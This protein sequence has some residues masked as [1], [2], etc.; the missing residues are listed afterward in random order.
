MTTAREIAYELLA[1][2]DEEDAYANLVMP[3]LLSAARNS[4]AHFSSRDAGFATELGYGTL[5]MR[6]WLNA[7]IDQVSSRPVD[8]LDASV[9]RVIQL[10]AYQLL[11]M[12]VSTHAAVSETV[13]LCRTVG[14]KSAAGFVNATLR[15]ISE[16][17]PEQWQDDIA[18]ALSIDAGRA[19]LSSHPEWI[20]DELDRSLERAGHAA[21]LDELLNADNQAPAVNLVSLPGIGPELST[22]GAANRFSPVGMTLAGGNPAKLTVNP[23]I[24]VQDEGSQ[25]AA[26][27]LV[28][29]KPVAAGERW[30]DLCAGP[31]GKAALLAAL[32]VEHDATLVANEISEHRAELVRSALQRVAPEV[33]VR[34][35]DG[36]A[37]SSERYDRILLDAPCSGLGALRRRP[38]A[39][40]RKQPEDLPAL[41]A[42]QAELIDSAL[43]ALSK[44]GVLAYVTCSP[45]LEET[46]EQVQRVVD[47]GAARLLDTAALLDTAS[48][49]PLHAAVGIADGTAVQL[50]PH[51]H[52]SDAM[53][54]ALL[55]RLG[56]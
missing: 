4:A 25:L 31:G 10:G 19:A 36:R 28:A 15:R 21:E 41:V 56:A 38:E 43:T 22:V 6:G 2:V 46:V 39:R 42:L 16:R 27:A 54:I 53:F 26:L 17:S 50:W 24:R 20:I 47:S 35:G 30:L 34:T 1:A 48:L 55:T 44:G 18:E 3:K 9:R 33:E 14:A 52:A 13:D 12:N 49:E 51:R 37:P 45:V 29:A 7:V 11:E 23:G 32:A 40:W 8:R 5:R